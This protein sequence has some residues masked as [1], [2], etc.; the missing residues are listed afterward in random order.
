MNRIRIGVV[1]TGL[2]W[3]YTHFPILE[4]LLRKYEI[5]ALCVRRTEKADYWKKKCPNAR[6]YSDYKDLVKDPEICAVLVA[7]PIPLNS[8][9]AVLALEAGKHVFLEK[10]I[11]TSLEDAI[12]IRESAKRNQRTVYMLEQIAYDPNYNKIKKILNGGDL[13]KPVFFERITHFYLSPEDKSAVAYGRTNWRINP[14]FPLGTIFDGGVHDIALTTL[15]FG[16]PKTIYSAGIKLRKE[17]GQY[18]HILTTFRYETS[19]SGCYSHSA[20]LTETTNV[21]KIWLTRGTMIENEN[22]I[23]ITSREGERQRIE[24][25][26]QSSYAYMW[27]ALYSAFHGVSET[28]YS[29]SDAIDSIKILESIAASLNRNKSVEL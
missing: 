13:G 19:M 21:F 23:I 28:A 20:F 15:L 7:T 22:G 27:D 26:E 29:I 2:I 17:M 6:I 18:D 14:E 4:S 24:K 16:M 5:R 10:P 3:E 9:V 12:T 11:S 25:S 1:G 8:S